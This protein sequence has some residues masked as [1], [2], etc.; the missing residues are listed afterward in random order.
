MKFSKKLLLPLL[1]GILVTQFYQNCGQLTQFEPIDTGSLNMGSNGGQDHPSSQ[2]AVAPS[3]KVLVQNRQYVYDL[4][5]EVFTSAT[6]P[7]PDLQTLLRHWVLNR[8]GQYGLACDPYSSHT[9]NDCG[10][11]I[12]N[13]N[14]SYHVDDNTVRESYR[15]QA[16]ENIL[17]M[18][19]AVY[20][21]MEKL[22]VKSAAPT[23][24][25]IREVYALFYRGDEASDSVVTSLQAF[26]RKLALQNETN[27]ERWRALILQVCESPGWQLQ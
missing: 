5:M 4:M 2:T 15:V 6:T 17:G 1:G 21:A 12:S 14:L 24:E 19:Q 8:P 7:V 23:S 22:P 11:A 27:L 20:A 10:G 3:Q 9:G 25:T 18:D 26:D 13:A 16:C